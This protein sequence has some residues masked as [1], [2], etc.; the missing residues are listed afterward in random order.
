MEIIL[1]KDIENL[2]DKHELV[3][4]KPGYGRNYLIP[5][6]M[7]I[8]ANKSNKARLNEMI[9][10][11]QFRENKRLNEYQEMANRIQAEVLKIGAKAGT[12]GK[13]FGSVTN[14]QIAQAIKEL[15]DIDVD[16]RKIE[17]PEEVKNIGTYH[18]V[19]NF[20]PEV[21]CKVNFEVVEE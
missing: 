6:G 2:G 14:V 21:S 10:Q 7:A 19:I 15:L 20:H 8:I 4:V 1:L 11:D 18:A 17:I 5:Q 9:R 13:I 16:R 12:S 3:T